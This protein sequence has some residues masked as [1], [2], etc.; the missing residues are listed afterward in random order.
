MLL[1]PQLLELL[2]DFAQ[3][4]TSYVMTPGL[5]S[6]EVVKRLSDRT[7]DDAQKTSFDKSALGRL[8]ISPL[9]L[10]QNRCHLDIVCPKRWSK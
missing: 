10:F 5:T 1:R 6:V 4:H 9:K 2:T 8:D 3:T 7:R